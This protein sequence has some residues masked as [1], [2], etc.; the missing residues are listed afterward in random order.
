VKKSNWSKTVNIIQNIVETTA[1]KAIYSQFV[2]NT[3]LV[4]LKITEGDSIDRIVL[5]EDDWSGDD[6]EDGSDLIVLFFLF[7]L[8]K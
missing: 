5:S 7:C 4:E 8:L 1:V 6:D 3:A 2:T